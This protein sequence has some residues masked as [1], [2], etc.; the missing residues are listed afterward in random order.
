ME[1]FQS[2]AAEEGNLVGC[3]DSAGQMSKEIS[4]DRYDPESQAVRGGF[5]HSPSTSENVKPSV[6]WN[7]H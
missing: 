3:D 5:K 4:Y 1:T 2:P 6:L 7:P